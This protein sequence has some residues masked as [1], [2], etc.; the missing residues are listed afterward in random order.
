MG[1]HTANLEV[2]NDWFILVERVD[3]LVNKAGIY[4]YNLWEYEKNREGSDDGRVEMFRTNW[5][6]YVSLNRDHT[7]FEDRERMIKLEEAITKDLDRHGKR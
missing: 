7:L 2:D 1:N 3:K 5:K 4:F 6:K